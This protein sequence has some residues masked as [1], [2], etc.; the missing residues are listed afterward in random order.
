M[1]GSETCTSG[2]YTDHC[3]SGSY[4]LSYQVTLAVK[5]ALTIRISFTTTHAI[6]PRKAG[7]CSSTRPWRR[8]IST[9]TRDQYSTHHLPRSLGDSLQTQQQHTYAAF[10]TYDQLAIQLLRGVYNSKR[11]ECDLVS[12]AYYVPWDASGPQ[13]ATCSRLEQQPG[14]LAPITIFICGRR[15]PCYCCY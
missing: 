5:E 7:P 3:Q 1:L 14:P 10:Q 12:F 4:T 2:S 13:G 15:V 9:A 11:Q 8:D 6:G